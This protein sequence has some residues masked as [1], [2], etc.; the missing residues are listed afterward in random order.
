M[1]SFDFIKACD[2][3]S[4]YKSNRMCICL[5]VPKVLVNGLTNMAAVCWSFLLVPIYN[6]LG[7]V[8]KKPPIF[9]WLISLGR[10]VV[11]HLLEC[12]PTISIFFILIFDISL[13]SKSSAFVIYWLSYLYLITQVSLCNLY[14]VTYRIYFFVQRMAIL[15]K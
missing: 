6:Y 5:R 10:V 8:Y 7:G 4:M 1:C 11:L 13:R 15:K 12:A 2:T 9:L 14:L 3:Q